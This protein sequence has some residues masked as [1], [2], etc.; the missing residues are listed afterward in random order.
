MKRMLFAMLLGLPAL[1][2]AP[3]FAVPDADEL[4]ANLAKLDEYRKNPAQLAR[5]RRDATAFL[6]LPEERRAHLHKLDHALQQEP[7]AARARLKNILERYTNWLNHL[8]TNDRQAVDGA[9]DT[10]A[11]L[12]V[13]REL[14]DRDWMDAQPRAV[15]EQ[16]Q[17]LTAP[18]KTALL[19]RLRQQERQ[20]QQDWQLAVRFWKDLVDGK[21][22]PTR[23]ADLQDR[24][25]E[26]VGEYLLPLLSKQ[27]RLRL[28]EAEGKW[29]AYALTLVELAD[30]HPFALPTQVGP[31]DVT[32]LPRA[33]QDLFAKEIRGGNGKKHAEVLNRIKEWP[34]FAKAVAS[35][36]KMNMNPAD[37]LPRELWA[38]DFKSL[39]KPMKE[40]VEKLKLKLTDVERLSLQ[41]AEGKW[42]EYP[43]AIKK[44][45][46]DHHFPP[47][48]W[49]TAL[50]GSPERWD[51]YRAVKLGKRVDAS[52]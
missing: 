28:K 16:W 45:A 47:P 23:L 18:E 44:L 14:R 12:V 20:R 48:P 35:A 43:L 2:T 38:W 39:Q 36:N 24:D 9:R 51:A 26:G 50:T 27:E 19:A 31:Q 17:V 11:R 21:P 5:L 32:Q 3:L 42:P 46:R 22:L 7:A 49:E 40:Y 4:K 37:R 33:I 1:M 30:A 13:V 34:K 52:R 10:A 8:P 25:R 29:P 41:D 6:A 15:R